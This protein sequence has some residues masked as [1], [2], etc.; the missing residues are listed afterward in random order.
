MYKQLQHYFYSEA[1]TMQ[2]KGIQSF[3]VIVVVVILSIQPRFKAERML[4]FNKNVLRVLLSRL[5]DKM[6]W[7]KLV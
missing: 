2:N 3:V 4:V 7:S 1:T 6:A 5:P